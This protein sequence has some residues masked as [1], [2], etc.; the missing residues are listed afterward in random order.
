MLK[1]GSS[2]S[3]LTTCEVFGANDVYSIIANNAGLSF[4][5]FQCITASSIGSGRLQLKDTQS[6]NSFRI[7]STYLSFVASCIKVNV[8]AEDVVSLPALMMSRDSPY[9]SSSPAAFSGVFLIICPTKSAFPSFRCYFL[10]S[11]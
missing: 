1:I 10:V 2:A 5:S 7:A 4:D 11:A 3:Q 8:N 9:S 6:R